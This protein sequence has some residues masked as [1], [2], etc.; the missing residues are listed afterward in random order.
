MDELIPL[1]GI[2]F[3]IGVPVMSVAAH[4]VLRPMVKDIADA[5]LTLKG[6]ASPE[7]EARLAELEEGQR[8]IDR[9]LESLIESDRFRQEL[10]AGG[11]SRS[12]GS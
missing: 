3:V 8:L 6:R 7:I 10:E 4:F 1:F 5:I 9:R 2:F 11:R 12:S